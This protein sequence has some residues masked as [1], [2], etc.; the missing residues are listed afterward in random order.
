MAT[1]SR[2]AQVYPQELVHPGC[3][4]SD[5]SGCARRHPGDVPGRGDNPFY[6]LL[7]CRGCQHV[8]GARLR[9]C[10][11]EGLVAVLPCLL[12][13]MWSRPGLRRLL[14]GVKADLADLE[15]QGWQDQSSRH[16]PRPQE[17]PAD[18]VMG[19]PALPRLDVLI[20]RE[21][22]YPQIPEEVTKTWATH[23][24]HRAAFRKLADSIISDL[25]PV[26]PGESCRGCEA[27][28]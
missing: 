14:D 26:A 9:C 27:Q 18:L 11:A 19:A 5:W 13:W 1:V 21:D 12:L 4:I 3:L 2:W 22:L 24:Q 6:R 25:W 8:C 17:M 10:G 23:S 7:V 20:Q 15:F 28:S 16:T